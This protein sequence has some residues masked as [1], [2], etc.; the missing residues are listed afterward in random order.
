MP[1]PQDRSLVPQTRDPIPYRRGTDKLEKTTEGS[2]IVN[3]SVPS[4]SQK[5]MKA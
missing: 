3:G 4:S 2:R 5:C 1:P